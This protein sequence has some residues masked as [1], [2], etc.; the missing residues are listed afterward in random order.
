MIAATLK[1]VK[2]KDYGPG[3]DYLAMSGILAPDEAQTNAT[4]RTWR[5][6]M[7][8]EAKRNRMYL[9]LYSQFFHQMVSKIEA[10]TVLVL[11]NNGYKGDRFDRNVLYAFKDFKQ[12]SIKQLNGFQ[13]YETMYVIWNFIKH[14]SLSAYETL[15]KANPNILIDQPY[16]QGQLANYYIKF[17]NELI[18]DIISGVECFFKEYCKL[19]FDED[20]DNAQWDYDDYFTSAVYTEIEGIINPLGLPDWI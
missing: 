3:D 14:N 6:H 17:S 20:Y 7:E 13:T 4:I 12:E 16:T 19:V 15:K 9:S 11:T 10:I 18:Q 8:A 5:S 1:K 2:G